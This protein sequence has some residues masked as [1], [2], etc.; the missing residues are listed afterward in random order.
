MTEEGSLSSCPRARTGQRVSADHD[1]SS[2]TRRR[3]R[4]G[5]MEDGSCIVMCI[6]VAPPR[7]CNWTAGPGEVAPA[8]SRH[9]TT[10]HIQFVFRPESCSSQPPSQHSPGSDD[11]KLPPSG[12]RPRKAEDRNTSSML[13]LPLG[14]PPSRSEMLPW[15][16][17][18][19]NIG[20]QHLH[21]LHGNDQ[22]Y[23]PR[24]FP[25]SIHR[26]GQR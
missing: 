9:N 19:S 20:N 3:S 17:L 24:P 2:S 26:P 10:A 23:G 18:D 11:D 6:V 21:E 13:T 15:F 12:L 25:T 14:P 8:H 16:D 4:R 1:C 7:P 22:Q 5:E